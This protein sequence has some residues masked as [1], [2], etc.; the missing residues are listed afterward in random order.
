MQIGCGITGGYD[1][2]RRNAAE[3]VKC[4][5][6]LLTLCADEMARRRKQGVAERGA[7]MFEDQYAQLSSTYVHQ[8]SSGHT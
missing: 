3:Y 1:S 7:R 4:G 2:G 6:R 8:P 5:A